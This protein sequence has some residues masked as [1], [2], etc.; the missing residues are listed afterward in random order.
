METKKKSWIYARWNEKIFLLRQ[1]RNTTSYWRRTLKG[2]LEGRI[3]NSVR[4]VSEWVDKHEKFLEWFDENKP[5]GQKRHDK[6]YNE[7]KETVDAVKDQL[8][9][10]TNLDDESTVIDSLVT[11][12]IA[13]VVSETGLVPNEALNS[14]DDGAVWFT[15]PDTGENHF[16]NLRM[17][18][19]QTYNV[20]QP[21]GLS[22]YAA[23]DGVERLLN[24]YIGLEHAFTPVNEFH[25]DPTIAIW[26]AGNSFRTGG[27]GIIPE[28]LWPGKK[29]NPF[30]TA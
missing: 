7:I 28:G 5:D 29:S 21:F 23:R 24:P 30:K 8:A 12:I 20:N 22:Y 19:N 14:R 3:E 2:K 10:F 4:A 11:E 16:F 9:V 1:N 17:L 26:S 25:S 15:N 18:P 13:I 27:Y 6:F